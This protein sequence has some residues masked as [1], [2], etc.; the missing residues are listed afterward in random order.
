M[1][2]PRCGAETAPARAPQRCAACG[3]A[4][5]L[6][7]GYA[8]DPSVVPPP[9]DQRRPRVEVKAAGVFQY[10][11]GVVEHIGVSEGATDPITGLIPVEQ[12]GVMYPDI[13]SI[14]VWRKPDWMELV[15]AL[16]VPV[17]ITLSLLAVAILN[18]SIGAAIPAA[19][20]ALLSALMIRRA[21]STQRHFVRVVGRYRVITVRFDRPGWRRRRFHD[22]LLAR[23]G[24][25]PAPIP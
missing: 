25:P 14:A 12:S 7:P 6:Y 19:L 13:V 22:E 11:L 23:A 16:L 10:R 4:F 2:C 9:P 18:E 20:F 15:I 8:S 24:L 5:A 21:M 17:P 1:S 3:G